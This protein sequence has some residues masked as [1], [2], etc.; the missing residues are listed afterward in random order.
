M[1]MSTL[2]R[3]DPEVYQAIGLEEGR[4]KDKLELIAS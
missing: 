4:Q 3:Q 1:S 2:A